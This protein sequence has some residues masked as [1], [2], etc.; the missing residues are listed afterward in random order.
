MVFTKHYESGGKNATETGFI[1][2]ARFVDI[3]G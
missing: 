2:S 1:L 3:I